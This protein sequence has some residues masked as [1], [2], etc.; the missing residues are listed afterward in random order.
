MKK[1][2][3]AVMLCIGLVLTILLISSFNKQTSGTKYASIRTV[4]VAIG[5]SSR[6]IVVYDGKTEEFELAKGSAGNF[7]P[8]TAQINQAVN[9]LAAKGY[10]LVSQS[11]G[12]YISM[13]TF[14]KTR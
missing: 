13:Y 3:N 9:M 12:D 11:G 5:S 4:E 6:I 2:A 14:A 1:K 7:S 8:N 10:E